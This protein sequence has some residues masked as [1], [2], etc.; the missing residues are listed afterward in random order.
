MSHEYLGEKI[1]NSLNFVEQKDTMNKKTTK[2][3]KLL[4]RIRCNISP[5]IT[6]SIYKIMIEPVFFY[7]NGIFL[8]DFCSSMTKFKK[9]RHRPFRFAGTMYKITGRRLRKEAD[10]VRWTFLKAKKSDF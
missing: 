6:Q 4:S 10:H 8:E 5:L 9:V 7:C 2:P 1:D 3:V